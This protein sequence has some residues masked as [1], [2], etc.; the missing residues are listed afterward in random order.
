MP[1][2]TTKFTIAVK[3]TNLSAGEYIKVTNH[4]SGGTIRQKIKTGGECILNPQD[5]NLSWSDGDT[6][7]IESQGRIVFST[8]TT[9][10]K[11]GAKYTNNAAGTADDMPAV[12]L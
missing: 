10:S 1:T 2:P 4:T 3:N 6:I 7:S 9:I 5:E 8:S 12:S 11:G